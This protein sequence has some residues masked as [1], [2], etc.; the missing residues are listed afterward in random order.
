[1]KKVYVLLTATNT[2]FARFIRFY[3]KKPYSHASISFKKDCTTSY[4]FSRTYTHNPFLGSFQKEGIDKGIFGLHDNIPCE[5]LEIEVAEEQYRELKK[6]VQE[7]NGKKYNRLG[8]LAKL[9]NI[10]YDAK[11]KYFCSEFVAYALRETNIYT[12]QKPLNFVEPC[13]FLKMPNAHSIYH[14]NFKEKGKRK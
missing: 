4:S 9:L 13:D 3:T 5:I 10:S 1:M 6:I 8:L 12:F 2:Y 11:T 7:M 14:G